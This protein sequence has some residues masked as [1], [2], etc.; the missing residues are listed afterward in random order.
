[1]EEGYEDPAD[2]MD[3]DAFH[4]LLCT[5]NYDQ[6]T[7]DNTQVTPEDATQHDPTEL[8]DEAEP[9]DETNAADLETESAVVIDK[10]PFGSAGMPVPG[11]LP[12]SSAYET[13]QNMHADTSW[14][15]FS[16]QLDWDIAQWAKMCSIT[17]TA[18]TELLAIP[19]VCSS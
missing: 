16:S 9:D 14:A 19:G 7:L 5:A 8:E 3:V 4:D 18:V 11:M 15:P 12:G 2:V 13:L 1:L 6:A 17:S 10:F